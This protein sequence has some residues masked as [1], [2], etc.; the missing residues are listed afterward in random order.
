M[1]FSFF[2]FHVII[3]TYKYYLYKKRDVSVMISIGDTL[4]LEPKN[5]VEIERYRC[6]V[7]EISGNQIY[8]DYPVNLETQRTVFLLDGTQLKASFI[9]KNG[10]VYLFQTEVMGRLKQ[11]IPML[12][13]YYPGE[14]HL[15][16]IQRRQFVRIEAPVDVAVHPINN[17]FEPFTTITEDISA[18]G[19]ALILPKNHLFHNGDTFYLWMSLPMNSGE[20]HY[21]KLKSKAIRLIENKETNN[22]LSIQFLETS[23]QEKQLLLRFCFEKQL[24]LKKK[25][26]AL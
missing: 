9:A 16:K 24:E 6:K 15:I 14:E 18:G 12:K 22:L 10:S 2:L 13:L 21:L 7:V 23:G 19:A 4:T 20:Y 5:S 3:W 26:L 1:Y 11:N 8:I 25:G 17:E